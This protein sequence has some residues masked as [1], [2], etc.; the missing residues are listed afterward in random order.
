M[1]AVAALLTVIIYEYSEHKREFPKDDNTAAHRKIQAMSRNRERE[2]GFEYLTVYLTSIHTHYV[3]D[4]R[5]QSNISIE[6]SAAEDIKATYQLKFP[7][8]F[9]LDQKT[10]IKNSVQTIICPNCC[11]GVT[12]LNAGR[13]GYCE[14]VIRASE[15]S[16]V[17][18]D[19]GE[20]LI[21]TSLADNRGVIIRNNRF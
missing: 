4:A 3:L 16:W 1:V 7:R 6:G 21:N 11:G 10:N 20:Y 15:F 17:L 13:C 2:P 9:K 14:S 8:R 19:I 5:R 18:S 12:A